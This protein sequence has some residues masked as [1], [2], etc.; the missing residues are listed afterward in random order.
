VYSDNQT[1]I[2]KSVLDGNVEPKN[3]KTKYQVVLKGI[4]GGYE[5]K[6]AFAIKLSLLAKVPVTR[7]KFLINNTP[8][9]VWKGFGKSK[10]QKYL[11][12]IEESGGLGKIIE[13]NK[14]PEQAENSSDKI[15]D[16]KLCSQCGFPLNKDDK[17]C[18]F[19]ASLV[20]D[21]SLKRKI[22]RTTV[23]NSKPSVTKGRMV[24]YLIAIAVLIL[25][26]L[27]SN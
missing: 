8:S 27:L 2:Y 7:T 16:R 19:C 26:A 21:L 15:K 17:F 3:E 9:V 10:A 14:K 13:E 11:S 18:P 24:L 5:T 6:S 20:A 23:K 12:M 22:K 4:D 1:D 25:F